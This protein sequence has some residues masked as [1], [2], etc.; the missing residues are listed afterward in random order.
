MKMTSVMLARVQS[1]LALLT[2]LVLAWRLRAGGP[3]MENFICH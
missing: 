3:G 1:G 2:A